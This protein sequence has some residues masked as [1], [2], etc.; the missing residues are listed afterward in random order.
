MRSRTATLV[1]RSL[2]IIGA[3]AGLWLAKPA[4]AAITSVTNIAG[5]T[6]SDVT[7]KTDSGGVIN[8]CI[9]GYPLRRFYNTTAV[10]STCAPNEWE[11]GNGWVSGGALINNEATFRV[12]HLT[13]STPYSIRIAQT[14]IFPPA[15]LDELFPPLSVTTPAKLTMT[16]P[17]V[18]GITDNSATVS[19][20]T[21]RDADTNIKY[22]TASPN[23]S[24]RAADLGAINAMALGSPSHIV[25]V[26]NNGVIRSTRDSGQTWVAGIVPAGFNKSLYSVTAVDMYTYWAVGA[27]GTILYSD[28]AGVTWTV[29]SSPTTEY[30]YGIAAA[31]ANR[32][33]AVGS[34]NL[35]VRTDDAGSTWSTVADPG[36]PANTY[37]QDV[38]A[39]SA[40]DWFAVGDHSVLLRSTDG[41]MSWSITTPPG[42]RV[43]S[44]VDAFNATTALTVDTSGS[45][46]RTTDGVNWSIISNPG[47]AMY[48]V[49]IVSS[50]EA[51]VFGFSGFTSRTTNLT[52]AIPSW[53]TPVSIVSSD[54]YDSVASSQLDVWAISVGGTVMNYA[55]N[56]GPPNGS[57]YYNV[58]PALGH[59]QALTPL[60][61]TTHY[62]SRVE[63]ID[64]PAPSLPAEQTS[65]ST[66][67]DFEFTTAVCPD[68]IPPTVTIDTPA[69]NEVVRASPLT[70]TGTASDNIAVT[71]VQLSVNGG[72]WANATG[73]NAWTFA[74]P[75]NPWPATNTLNARA[76]DA[77]PNTSAS[78]PGNEV[79][80]LI[81]D[82]QDP[83]VRITSH[84]NNDNVPAAAITLVG[85]ASDNY[86]LSRVR[87]RLNSQPEVDA[88]GTTNWS[89][90]L[91][92]A[93]GSN[94][95]VV[96]AIDLAGRP[97]SQTITLN[98]DVDHPVLTITSHV[99]NQCV[100]S[101]SVLFQGTAT[102]SSGI[103][104]VTVQANGGLIQNATV[105]GPNWTIAL[106][107]LNEGVNT[108][109][110][111]AEDTVGKQTPLAR[112][113]RIDLNDPEIRIT[114]HNSG[115]TVITPTPTIQGISNDNPAVPAPG[116]TGYSCGLGFVEVQVTPRPVPPP[117][118]APFFPATGTATWNYGLGGANPTL[119]NGSNTL[120]A[121]V[122]DVSGRTR[123]TGPFE[124]ILDNNNPEVFIT[125]PNDGDTVATATVNV[126]GTAQDNVN[127]GT[128]Q[129][130]LN[131]GSLQ[132]VT[133]AAPL[134]SPGPFN[135]NVNLGPLNPLPATNTVY[136]IATD[137]V[138][139]FDEQTIFVNYQ[140][141]DSTP[142]TLVGVNAGPGSDCPPPPALPA[143]FI[144][145]TWTT[146]EPG[147]SVVRYGATSAYEL[148]TVRRDQPPG[149]PL[150]VA[151]SVRLQTGVSPSTL[152]YISVTSTDAA[153]NTNNPPTLLQTTSI[154]AC[155]NTAPNPVTISQPFVPPPVA[156][157]YRGLETVSVSAADNV[158]VRQIE[159]F[160]RRV[161]DL[162]GNPVT[163]PE[164]SVGPAVVCNVAAPGTCTRN[165]GWDTRV[166]PDE[167]KGTYE[168]TARASDPSGNIGSSAVVSVVVN[169]DVVAPEIPYS[170]VIAQAADNGDGTWQ[171]TVSWC[172]DDPGTTARVE[173]GAENLDD[174]R[175]AYDDSITG[176]NC[177]PPGPPNARPTVAPFT[178]C[179]GSHANSHCVQING[180]LANQRYHYQVESCDAAGNCGH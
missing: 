18:S 180:L 45:V 133:T 110:V 49:E 31:S 97:R 135:W 33:I 175:Y 38:V 125:A 39:V 22:S 2:A 146:N 42:N 107:T 48:A 142:P 156:G 27:T 12:P 68:P 174:L 36:M 169:N 99:N 15:L 69:D 58:T 59:S 57:S 61:C 3:L 8:W 65:R 119:T 89:Q 118:T 128:V 64:D 56:Y 60:M 147:D 95:I 72:P 151:H 7:V 29:M 70:V 84:A 137:N 124:L 138:G 43:F 76:H 5:P 154:G 159:L 101:R 120:F 20:T 6:W 123:D 115:D 103:N 111:V 85:T 16:A 11:L 83:D 9:V 108:L 62:Y 10:T 155:D 131:G 150:V 71:D 141:P 24:S 73:T 82:D 171:V 139:L 168:L 116:T 149:N 114:S 105:V 113:L 78:N 127:V 162:P 47:T 80:N 44:S 90:G 122:T 160:A 41:G 109:N 75:L 106:T 165:I 66:S 158:E 112:T 77:T 173:Y 179:P 132:N 93:N 21:N 94:T 50:T 92:L 117:P 55:V 163:E 79:L 126:T 140:P 102:D 4:T 170:S 161:A 166:T 144:Y 178:A 88:S 167:H 53:S 40:S 35:I 63:S 52:A 136:V 1:I 145:V 32:L 177:P 17:T 81:Y 134:P 30:L 176:D 164:F 121:R 157:E 46:S 51:W 37:L 129:I 19:W 148:G 14:Q 54:L 100:N 67:T 96:T 26:G 86:G 25:L 172:V 104:R 34:N 153:G 74:A 152:Y 87:V 143:Y 130:R 13:P 98:L 28:D 23:W 91:T